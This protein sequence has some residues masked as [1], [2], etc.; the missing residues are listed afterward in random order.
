MHAG[1]ANGGRAN[2]EVAGYPF[3]FNGEAAKLS[4]ERRNGPK[5][6]RMPPA[7]QLTNH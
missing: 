3:D 5:A 7:R 6:E 1:L 4:V 2:T